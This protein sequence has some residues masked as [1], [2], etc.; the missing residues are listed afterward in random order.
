MIGTWL[1]SLSALSA[2]AWCWLNI[3]R[4]AK[5]LRHHL[6]APEAD[7]P[8]GATTDATETEA[9]AS[10]G[11]LPAV[12]ILTPG[13]DEAEHLPTVLPELCGQDYP[14]HT[15][16]FVDDA[17]TD[18][19]PQIT[20]ELTQRYDNLLSVR[21]DQPPPPGWMGKCWAIHR[22]Y[23]ALQ[24][25]EREASGNA[26]RETR[27][28]KREI[29]NAE[30]EAQ[31]AEPPAADL[32]IASEI[33]RSAIPV[34]RSTS[35]VPRSTFAPPASPITWLCFT[36]ADIHWHPLLL[37]RAIAYCQDH[38]A[39]LL[40]LAPT[41]RFG[42]RLEALVQLQLVLALGL[43]LP[44][45]AVTDPDSPRTLTGGAFILVRRSF[46]D[47]IGGHTAVKGEMVEDLKL[48]M[49]LKAQGA[50]HRAALAGQLQWCRM[51]DGPA[52][53]WEGLTK[54]AYAGFGHRVY[55]AL[56]ACLLLLITNVL[57]PAYLIVGA[58]GWARSP[59]DWRYPV[60]TLLA[61]VALLAQARALNAVRRIMDLPPAWAWTTP[62]GSAA[63][64]VIILGSILQYH[65]TGNAWKG[66]RYRADS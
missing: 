26:K 63:Y 52:D 9:A 15:V 56:P 2:A 65:T 11:D 36:D 7:A 12:A 64:L 48:G 47:Q 17:S 20:A 1:L 62:P 18:A 32:S 60:A 25:A 39:D 53:L 37:R 57:P 16:V 23:E 55:L 8:Q 58:L 28:A 35:P 29:P 5:L 33:P 41:L 44:Y 31:N 49:A 13:R 30:R 21:N 3:P 6:P 43:M 46:Y 40:G 24:N 51:Y 38:D 22:G 42:S 45:D 61:M 34:P 66:R 14:R 19:T 27:S 4:Y 50:R 54:N 10:A 59:G